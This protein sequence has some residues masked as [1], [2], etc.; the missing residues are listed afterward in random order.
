MSVF[1]NSFPYND[2]D[3]VGHDIADSITATVMALP[4]PATM[5]RLLMLLKSVSDLG[6]SASK[7]EKK[8]SKPS[9]G[10]LVRAEVITYAYYFFTFCCVNCI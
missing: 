1:F 4:S 8:K 7:R 5:G 3:I 2:T 10:S 6:G 9:V